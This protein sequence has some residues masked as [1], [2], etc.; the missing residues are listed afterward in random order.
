VVKKAPLSKISKSEVSLKVKAILLIVW[1]VFAYLISAFEI[2]RKEPQTLSYSSYLE[3]VI[4]ALW[5][6]KAL[7]M[8]ISI[9]VL[10]SIIALGKLGFVRLQR[11]FN[12]SNGP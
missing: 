4:A 9:L 2:A 7:Y 5:S 3:K 11:F 8:P 12:K 1:F 6:F 10:V